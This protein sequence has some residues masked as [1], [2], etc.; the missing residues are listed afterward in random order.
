MR[1][2][3]RFWRDRAPC[4]TITSMIQRHRA[5]YSLALFI[6]VLAACAP[7]PTLTPTPTFTPSVTPTPTDTPTVTPTPEPSATPTATVTPTPTATPGPSPTATATGWPMPEA[8][9]YDWTQ[10]DISPSV[11]SILG[12]MRLSF[13][14]TNEGDRLAVITPS[15]TDQPSAVYLVAPG[16]GAPVKVVDLPSEVEG[17]VYWS[18]DMTK[19]AYFLPSQPA[20]GVYV[21]DLRIGVSTRV[22]AT[23]SLNQGGFVDA[24]QWSP[25]STRLAMA[26]QGGYDVDI[27]VVSADGLGFT[28][29]TRHGAYDFWPRWSPD[30]QWIAFLSDRERCPTWEP[31]VEGTCRSETSLSPNG[32]QLHVVRA[33]S[34]YEVRR[35]SDEWSTSP[36]T[37]VS[38]LQIA[39]STGDS[40]LGDSRVS[41]W[42]ADISDGSARELT[43]PVGADTELNLNPQWA[44]DGSA[45]IFH[46]ITTTNAASGAVS[47]SDVVIMSP[48]GAELGRTDAFNFARYGFAADW[49]PD[50]GQATIGGRR[51]QCVYGVVILDRQAEPWRRVNPP[52]TSCDP[53]YSPD[54]QWI[55][56]NG[57]SPRVDGRLDLYVVLASSGYGAR[58][59]TAGLMGQIHSLGWVGG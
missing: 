44:P 2:V 1:L 41:L 12:E 38:N 6:L 50:A 54:G 36:P 56:F 59:L 14:H 25:D 24:P 42:I 46:Q 10:F 39:F 26:L 22:I 52:P 33:N 5:F 43:P 30:G 11:L 35:L 17:N 32:G 3:K 55:A 37:W 47:A 29:L 7:P 15:V 23:D 45:V 57:V 51:G 8:A 31:A 28:D 53:Q 9:G 4:D 13:V 27:Y 16:G 40:L 48:S 19:L 21:L 20:P 34:P 18:P 49:S 58:N